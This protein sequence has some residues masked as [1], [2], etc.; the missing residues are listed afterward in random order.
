MDVQR[1]P[2]RR[3]HRESL[4]PSPIILPAEAIAV[5]LLIFVVALGLLIR[6]GA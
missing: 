1:G 6:S 3:S 2:V 5:T 4:T